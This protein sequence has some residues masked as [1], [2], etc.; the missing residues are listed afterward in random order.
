MRMR[1]SARWALVVVATAVMLLVLAFPFGVRGSQ[2]A[3][4]VEPDV[5]QV[6]AGSSVID[7]DSFPTGVIS[8]SPIFHTAFPLT[9]VTSTNQPLP[10]PHAAFL[11]PP[12]SPHA[13]SNLNNA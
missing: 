10:E 1:R 6:T 2:H 5:Y 3:A 4:A 13:A 8:P 7:T 11:E 12:P 9:R